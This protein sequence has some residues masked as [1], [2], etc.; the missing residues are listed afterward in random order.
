MK[1]KS[2]FLLA[3][4]TAGLLFILSKQA[5]SN[6]AVKAPPIVQLTSLSVPAPL[7]QPSPE[8]LAAK[9]YIEHER[10]HYVALREYIIST[11]HEWAPA[12]NQ[13]DQD[14]SNYGDIADDIATVTLAREEPA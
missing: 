7:F 4:G 10:E 2:L 11:M 5:S 13:P 9:Q 3:L 12:A 14:V 6:T 8:Q 1:A